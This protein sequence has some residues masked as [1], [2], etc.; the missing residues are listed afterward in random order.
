[1]KK[2]FTLAAL[3]TGIS[4]ATFAQERIETKRPI[5][6]DRK[7]RMEKKFDRRTPEEIAL[8]QTDHLHEKLTLSDG[9]RSEIYALQL[10][11]AKRTATHR[12]EMKK[13]QAERH[14]DMKNTQ[15]WIGAILTP[16]QQEQ[17][18]ESYAQRRTGKNRGQ[19]REF[20]K[21]L[22]I[23]NQMPEIDNSEG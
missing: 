13:K 22:P 15:K 1:M 12:E 2:V 19:R 16:E 21:Q 4:L 9:Q 20:R 6:K 14:E 10:E 23:G 17:L 11:Y 7:P 8:Q 5:H 18:K 3:F